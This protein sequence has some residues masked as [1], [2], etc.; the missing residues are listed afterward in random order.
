MPRLPLRARRRSDVRFKP[1]VEPLEERALPSGWHFDFDS[2]TSPPAAGY[3]DVP[4]LL[5]NPALGYGWQ[6]VTGISA[7]DDG[8]S[9]PLTRDFH[10]AHEATF[11][12]NVSN[13]TYE[14]TVHL[15]DVMAGRTSVD[16]SAEGAFLA[17]TPP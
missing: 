4:V 3:T 5:Y 1:Y 13:G 8:T 14:V 16:L 11:Q 10:Q 15:G 12:A 6:S 2:L 7:V 9:D 17:L